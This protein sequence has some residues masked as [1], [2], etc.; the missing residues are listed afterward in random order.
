M[1]AA[2]GDRSILVVNQAARPLVYLK[3]WDGDVD[4]C[5]A[6]L[7]SDVVLKSRSPVRH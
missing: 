4:Y 6:D 5:L 7:I 3:R 2:G 1:L